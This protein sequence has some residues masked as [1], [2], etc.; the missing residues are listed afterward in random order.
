MNKIN[1]LADESLPGLWQ[2]FLPPF[3]LTT[4]QSDKE[5]PELICGKSVLLCRSTL[6]VDANLLKRAELVCVATASSGID[7][8][9]LTYLRQQGIH[10]FDAK[11]S[12]AI[13][14]ANYVLASL[15]YLQDKSLLGGMRVGIIGMG[16]V[17]QQLL[18][19]LQTIGFQ[20][21]TYDPLRKDVGFISDSFSDLFDCDVICV[22]PNL[23]HG[24]VFPSYHLLNADFF[25]ALKSDTV[26][27]NASRGDVVCETALLCSE[28]SFLY[29]TDV[30]A[31]EPNI[32][33]QLIDRA[34][35]CTPHIA[36]HT[37]E[38]KRRAVSDIAKKIH[39]FFRLPLPSVCDAELD[40]CQQI[41]TTNWVK[42]VL[43]QYDPGQETKQMKQ[44]SDK[45]EQFLSLR[46]KHQ[47]RHDFSVKNR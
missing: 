40:V 31:N 34:T 28:A 18:R 14:V 33:P 29:C 19:D 32:N 6:K 3:E 12:N 41:L 22:H 35:L 24:P 5:I 26:I 23:H 45:S 13:A 21:V 11:G 38:A 9:D 43:V 30:Y 7:H 16:A 39:D 10:C 17:G 46:R 25:K 4:Y 37:I 1:V 44:A 27:I 36:G 42:Q 8:I 47:F 20:V 2:F 15:A